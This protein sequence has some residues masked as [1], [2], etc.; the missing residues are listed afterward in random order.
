[1]RGACTEISRHVQTRLGKDM[2]ILHSTKKVEKGMYRI[3][4][5][6]RGGIYNLHYIWRNRVRGLCTEKNCERALNVQS[7][8]CSK[9][10]MQSG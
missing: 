10:R 1:M 3:K 4:L 8:E 7:F 6:E 2:Y 5:G 9:M